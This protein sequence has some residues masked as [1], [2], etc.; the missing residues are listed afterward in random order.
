M[1]RGTVRGILGVW[2]VLLFGC[3][4]GPAP[5]E[6][7]TD[8]KVENSRVALAGA[9]DGPRTAS[10]ANVDLTMLSSKGVVLATL[11]DVKVTLT[12]AQ[13]GAGK[14][15]CKATFA[16]TL[17]TS[18]WCTSPTHNQGLGQVLQI[19]LEKGDHALVLPWTVG[20]F[21]VDGPQRTQALSYEK[22]LDVKAL[23]P[24]TAEAEIIVQPCLWKKCP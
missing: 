2:S 23:G 7:F 22:T 13:D 5:N 14:N 15:V 17:V 3:C 24:A 4:S 10:W 21:K 8:I 20:A 16:A 9:A 18:Q 11:K 19:Y 12:P 1:M 6:G